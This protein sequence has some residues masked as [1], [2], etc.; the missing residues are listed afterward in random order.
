MDQELDTLR[1]LTFVWQPVKQEENF[2]FKYIKF[3]LKIDLVTHST[4]TKEL[5]KYMNR[6]KNIAA[7][8]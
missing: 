3:R 1:F 4:R 6:M 2:E 5:G 8:R 7:S